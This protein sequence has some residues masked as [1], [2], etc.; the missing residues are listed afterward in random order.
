MPDT[1]I[2]N[3]GNPMWIYSSTEGYVYRTET[4][5]DQH[6]LQKIGNMENKEELVAVLK[7]S[8]TNPKTGKRV[9]NTIALSTNDL[10]KRL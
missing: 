10:L 8:A 5:I 2:F 4:F 3:D 9:V 1:I 7:R 6:I